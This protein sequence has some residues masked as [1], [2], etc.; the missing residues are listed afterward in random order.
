MNSSAL[1]FVAVA[2]PPYT[3]IQANTTVQLNKGNV[4]PIYTQQFNDKP[5]INGL[6]IRDLVQHQ[7]EEAEEEKL[8]LLNKDAVKPFDWSESVFKNFSHTALPDRWAFN[9]YTPNWSW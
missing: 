3:E 4:A 8:E 6:E 9:L 5:D 2:G 7:Q 1:E